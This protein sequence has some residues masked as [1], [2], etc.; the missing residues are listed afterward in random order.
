[1]KKFLAL[2]LLA[3]LLLAASAGWDY[4]WREIPPTDGEEVYLGQLDRYETDDQDREWGVISIDVEPYTANFRSNED[5][6]SGNTKPG[7]W[8][9]IQLDGN[10]AYNIR[11]A[12]IV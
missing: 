5:T 12:V 4:Y 6:N 10:Y 1:M 3:T 7:T 11:P 9:S 8:L 2:L